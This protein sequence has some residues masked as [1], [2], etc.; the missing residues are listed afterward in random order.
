VL[1]G[2]ENAVMFVGAW[3]LVQTLRKIADLPPAVQIAA[4]GVVVAIVAVLVV[5]TQAGRRSARSGGG[6]VRA[7]GPIDLAE[8]WKLGVFY[9]NPEDPSL[10][11]P[12]RSSLG[13][14]LNFANPWSWLVL[15]LTLLPAL[16]LAFWLPLH[17]ASQI[18]GGGLH[19]R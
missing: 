12:K 11:V 7:G 2:D 6:T 8:S 13:Y 5:A 18:H 17:I 14:T 19:R 10:F 16:A 4:A 15:A 3:L 1:A 9:F